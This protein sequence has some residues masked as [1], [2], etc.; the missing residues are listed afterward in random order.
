MLGVGRRPRTKRAPAGT[1]EDQHSLTR[2]TE[3]N[4]LDFQLEGTGSLG[5]VIGERIYNRGDLFQKKRFCFNSRRLAGWEIPLSL[6]MK[7]EGC[8][9]RVA[10]MRSRGPFISHA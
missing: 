10:C 4:A 8:G 2:R 1:S 7:D 3:G 5:K 9:K 6:Q